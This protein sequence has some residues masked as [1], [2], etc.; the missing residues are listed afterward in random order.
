MQIE[1]HTKLCGKRGLISPTVETM[2]KE[3]KDSF[4]MFAS[5]AAELKTSVKFVL[6]A[7]LASLMDWISAGLFQ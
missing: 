4:L 7:H 3:E 6:Y 2:H 5:L 1:F